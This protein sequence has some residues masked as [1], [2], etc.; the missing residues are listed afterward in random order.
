MHKLEV[1]N[2]IK[3]VY[4]KQ[5]GI[6]IPEINGFKLN[7][8]DIEFIAFLSEITR[9]YNLINVFKRVEK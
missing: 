1:Q 8:K 9:L 2:D 5:S 6:L 3:L 7:Y 4:L